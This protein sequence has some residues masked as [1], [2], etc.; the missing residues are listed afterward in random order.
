MHRFFVS[1][2]LVATVGS[3]WLV[4]AQQE[5]SPNLV[6]SGSVTGTVVMLDQ[7]FEPTVAFARF[8]PGARTKWHS[9][10]AGQIILVEEGFAHTQIKDGPVIRLGA[11]ETIYSGPGVWHWHGAAPDDG[12]VQYNVTRG[13]VTW[14]DAVTDEEY[15]AAPVRP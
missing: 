14:G 5:Q 1:S 10:E 7:E 8:E 4:H 2:V 6:G 15:R 9:H 3:F 11:G 12:C 13:A